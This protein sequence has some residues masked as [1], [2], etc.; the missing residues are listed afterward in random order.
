MNMTPFC[1]GCV[2][3][4]R[5]IDWLAQDAKR[6]AEFGVDRS[7][8]GSLRYRLGQVRDV[9][10]AWTHTRGRVAVFVCCVSCSHEARCRS[11]GLFRKLACGVG[12]PSIISRRFVGLIPTVGSSSTSERACVVY[13]NGLESS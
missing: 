8:K 12:E 5:K 13:T 1:C 11:S 9:V 10:H 3:L 4:S 7:G 2:L 6:E